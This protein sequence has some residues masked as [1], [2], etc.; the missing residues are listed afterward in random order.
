MGRKSRA[1]RD[2]REQGDFAAGLTACE[3]TWLERPPTHEEELRLK[4]AQQVLAQHRAEANALGA[5]EEALQRF[6]LE[7]F[8]D[9]RFAPLRFDDWLVEDVLDKFG[10]PPIAEE[11]GDTAFSDYLRAAVLWVATSR[12]RRAIGAQA[13]RFMPAYVEAGQIRHA[14]ALDY[15]T[16][17]TVMSDAV[18]PLLAQMMVGALSRWYDEHEDEEDGGTE[19]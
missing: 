17:V 6:S 11:E 1:K 14:L 10:E 4:A 2:R 9:E 19:P 5:D 13:R 3:G 8:R 15:N 7:L 18:T 16:Y 12:V